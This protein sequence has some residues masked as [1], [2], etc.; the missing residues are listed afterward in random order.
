MGNA[1]RA[2]IFGVLLTAAFLG[3]WSCKSG[4]ANDIADALA[5]RLNDALAFDGESDENGPPPEGSSAA[6][7][8]Q[9]DSLEAPLELSLGQSF[10][11]ALVSLFDDYS[12]V[13]GAIVHVVG[14]KSYKRVSGALLRVIAALE[15]RRAMDLFGRL[16]IDKALNGY[17]GQIDI[18]LQT[19]D[20]KIGA[21]KRLTLH[22][23]DAEAQATPDR[24]LS[25]DSTTDDVAGKAPTA[26]AEVTAPQI[27]R[28]DAPSELAMGA[29]FALTLQSDI[30]D[31]ARLKALIVA[32]PQADSYRQVL[33]VDKPTRVLD[34]FV[35]RGS[36]AAGGLTLGQR[37][38]YKL[39]LLSEDGLVGAYRSWSFVVVAPLAEDGD[40]D[41]TD[42]DTTI[43]DGDSEAEAEDD[44]LC[45]SCNANAPCPK[46]YSCDASGGVGVCVQDCLQIL[47]IPAKGVGLCPDGF[48]CTVTSVNPRCLPN[49]VSYACT[50]NTLY[51]TDTCERRRAIVECPGGQVCDAVSGSCLNA[52]VDGDETDNDTGLTCL[53]NSTCCN[54]DGFWMEPGT[55]CKEGGAADCLEWVCDA[56]HACVEK[57]VEGFC[58]IENLGCMED[59][60]PSPVNS[61][62]ACDA[63][64]AP[65]ALTPLA[66]AQS[67][68]D[69]NACTEKDFC[70][71]ATCVSGTQVTCPDDQN[72]CTTA[73]CDYRL[74]CVQLPQSDLACPAPGP[75]ALSGVCRQG[76]CQAAASAPDCTAC[77]KVPSS[78]EDVCIKGQCLAREKGEPFR[79][80]GS[81]P[82]S[83]TA[84]AI[85]RVKIPQ[86]SVCI[87]AYEASLV[88]SKSTTTAI[89]GSTSDDY[90]SC[91]ATDGTT[92]SCAYT[93][94][95]QAKA[96]V[97]PSRYLTWARAV[98]LCKLAGERLCS[99]R[100]W[101]T[102]CGGPAGT[103]Y[104][105]G[106]SYQN[107]TCVDDA[108]IVGANPMIQLK[109]KATGCESADLAFDMVGNVDEWLADSDGNSDGH[110][111]AGGSVYSS[112]P[113]C[114]T[115][116][117]DYPF[118][119]P[120]QRGVRCC[121]DVPA[122]A[123]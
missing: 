41:A 54:S 73:S 47:R 77:A 57:V 84:G 96:G 92:T 8:P 20:G 102:A 108:Y 61:C 7:A 107:S 74:G 35:V 110:Y 3:L 95:A 114:T 1:L 69:G 80:A 97:L 106:A 113:S 75:C 88:A 111:V 36:L 83:D 85:E 12:R 52:A 115:L 39:A 101:Q 53:A 65:R 10:S 14:A 112:K 105:Y 116:I 50:D 11:F 37:L 72:P 90:G 21:Y 29:E 25:F 33:I 23:R 122:L 86:T 58:Y 16:K 5:D 104:P 82:L 9:L 62:L 34:P 27:L 42:H 120:A 89:L 44:T 40:A 15:K 51:A 49:T 94:S 118:N 17:V 22:I 56:S 55:S 45:R 19:R 30:T 103:A 78:D 2:G 4:D 18:A 59:T 66:D 60:T 26:S 48:T 32:I 68:D 79:C 98:S 38:V 24:V 93:L 91:L 67:C 117:G 6:E 64:K 119:G 31:P 63:G 121:L 13:D 123:R 87:D 109:G 46:G 100:E 99:V 76:V 71:N 43:V 28:L 70:R 81:C